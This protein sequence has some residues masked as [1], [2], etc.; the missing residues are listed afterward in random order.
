MRLLFIDQLTSELTDRDSNQS[1]LWIS[2]AGRL[3]K[4]AKSTLAPRSY[5]QQKPK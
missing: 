5:P 2:R 1:Q 4:E 3:Y